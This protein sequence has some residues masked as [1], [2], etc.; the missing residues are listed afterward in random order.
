MKKEITDLTAWDWFMLAEGMAHQLRTWNEILRNNVENEVAWEWIKEKQVAAFETLITICNQT[1]EKLK[2][3][4]PDTINE[5]TSKEP[6][7]AEAIKEY[8]K[9]IEI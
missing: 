7:I 8:Y 3:E 9:S 2:I 4:E 6:D 1:D 5:P